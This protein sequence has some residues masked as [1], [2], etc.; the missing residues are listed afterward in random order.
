MLLSRFQALDS[1]DRHQSHSDIE[2]RAFL[3]MKT[4]LTVDGSMP[5]PLRTVD[6]A[7]LAARRIERWLTRAALAASAGV[8]ARM[9]FFYEGGRHTPTPARLEQLAVALDCGLEALTGARRGEETLVDLRYAAGLTLER[10]TEIPRRSDVGRD[11]A[12]SAPKIS[13]LERG[14]LVRGR[15][16]NDPK[17]TGQLLKPLAKAYGGPIRMVLDAWMRTRPADTP[18]SPPRSRNSEPSAASKA[19]WDLIEITCDDRMTE[20]EIWMRRLQH[21]SVPPAAQWRRLPL[22][23]DA[24]PA[25]V[26]HTRLQQRLQA[27]GVH[28]PGAGSTLQ[29]LQKRGL[30][31]VTRDIVEHPAAGPVD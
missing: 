14:L 3:A 1:R 16:W 23:L 22:A 6:P 12:V 30:V 28:D 2:L 15:G 26:S 13:A 10:A 31:T 11:L 18:P 4:S 20:T 27:R 24:D 17:A 5:P 7:R 25:L 29:A 19:V 9:V 21:L 8:T